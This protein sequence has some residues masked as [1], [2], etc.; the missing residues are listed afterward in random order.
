MTFYLRGRITSWDED[1]ARRAVTPFDREVE[2]P[3]PAEAITKVRQSV[4]E[5]VDRLSSPNRIAD[6]QLFDKPPVWRF[7]EEGRI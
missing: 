4:R 6:F 2:A 7:S 1:D 5:E 3:T